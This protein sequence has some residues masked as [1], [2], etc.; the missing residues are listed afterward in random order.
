MHVCV[1]CFVFFENEEIF[2]TE[3]KQTKKHTNKEQKNNNK[4]T[5]YLEFWIWYNEKANKE[6]CMTKHMD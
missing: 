2:L 5:A 1:F 6:V 4:Q 3:K